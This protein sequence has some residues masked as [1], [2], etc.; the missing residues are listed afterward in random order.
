MKRKAVLV[1]VTSLSLAAGV[2]AADDDGPNDGRRYQTSNVV[3]ISGSALGNQ[4]AAWLI[5]SRN[6]IE[7]RI[8]T[9]VSTPGLPYTLWILL[10]NNPSKCAGAICNPGD[11]LNPD[12]KGVVYNGSGAIAAVSDAVDSTGQPIGAGVVNIDFRLVAGK[13]PNDLFILWPDAENRTGLLRNHGFR[14]EVQLV[15]DKHPAVVPGMSWI[16]DLTTTNFPGMGGAVGD[17]R[18]RFVS[19]PQ[20]SCPESAL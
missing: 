13:L 7:G 2:A 17:R 18:A 10:Y 8:M 3:D 1:L 20:T 4:G 16:P 15:V 14:A 6:R 19:C 12:V 11:M 5:R 9:T